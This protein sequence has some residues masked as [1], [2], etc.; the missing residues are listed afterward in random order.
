MSGKRQKRKDPIDWRAFAVQTISGVIS[1]VI[2]GLITKL[3]FR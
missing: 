3:I 1:G 2:A